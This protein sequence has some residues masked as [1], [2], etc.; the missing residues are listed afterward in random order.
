MIKKM[1]KTH[2]TLVENKNMMNPHLQELHF[3]LT[4]N[5]MKEMMKM[6]VLVKQLVKP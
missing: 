5:K 3:G 2:P 1:V 4:M 6:F